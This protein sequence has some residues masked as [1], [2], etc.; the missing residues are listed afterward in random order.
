MV[1]HYTRHADN[2]G[3]W[4]A[5]LGI[6]TTAV[7]LYFDAEVIDL[8]TCTFMWPRLAPLYDVSQR[9]RPWLPHSFGLNQVDLP[10]A[11]EANM[12]GIAWDI[13][14]NPCRPAA[15]RTEATLANIQNIVTTLQKFPDDFQVVRN[16]HE[17]RKA[18]AAGK[19]AS[20][21]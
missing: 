1:L 18:R 21:I 19:T 2:P 15:S 4:A 6:S 12:A 9:H 14:T 5:A 11:R 20:L 10:R 16:L 3:G 7:E 8:H 13:P 17:Y